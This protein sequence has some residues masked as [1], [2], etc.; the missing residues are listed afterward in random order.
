MP[1]LRA[2]SGLGKW[3]VP[4]RSAVLA[5]PVAAPADDP[6][7]AIRMTLPE[8]IGLTSDVILTILQHGRNLWFGLG[9]TAV[10]LSGMPP[11]VR[12]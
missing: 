2:M 8:P 5:E 9:H 7:Y 1:A 10:R 3:P 6:V 11:A 4:T 12:D